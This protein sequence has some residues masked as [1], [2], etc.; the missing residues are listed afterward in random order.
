MLTIV[1]LATVLKSFAVKYFHFG[2][3][4]ACVGQRSLTSPDGF[5][6][7]SCKKPRHRWRHLMDSRQ[8]I[9]ELE[10]YDWENGTGIGAVTGHNNLIVLDFDDCND[11]T[12]ILL[13]LTLLGLTTKYEWAV[14]SG[15]GNG[16][17]IWFFVTGELPECC[18]GKQVITFKSI[19]RDRLKQIEIRLKQHTVLP[20]SIH[21]SGNQYSFLNCEFPE[22]KPSEVTWR[23]V[24]NMLELFVDMPTTPQGN[25]HLQ[26]F[27]FLDKRIRK[28]I[29][30]KVQ[31]LD[32][33]SQEFPDADILELSND[34]FKFLGKGGFFVNTK[35]NSWWCFEDE[36]GGGPLEAIG[37]RLFGTA[38]DAANKDHWKEVFDTAEEL[39][40]TDF[41]DEAYAEYLEDL[42]KESD[43]VISYEITEFLKQDEKGDAKLFAQINNKGLRFNFDEG[44]WYTYTSGQ[45]RK[46]KKQSVRTKLAPELTRVYQQQIESLTSQAKVNSDPQ[47]LMKSEIQELRNRIK[48]L[49]K[50]GRS[51]GV[52]SFAASLLGA[53]SKDFDTNPLLF[54][55]ANGT[56]D[57]AKG[58]L[59][60]HSP[61]DLCTIQADYCYDP[62]VTCPTFDKFLS[63]MFRND[64]E[65]LRYMQKSIGLFLSG[66]TDPGK[67]WYFWGP[68][69][70][71]KTTLI[72]ILKML[73]G[74]YFVPVNVECLLDGS[75]N[76]NA[77]FSLAAVSKARVVIASELP[78]G[79]LLNEARLKGLTGGDPIV[80]RD[81]YKQMVSFV[82]RFKLVMSGNHPLEIQSTGTA[83]A[84][85]L[86]IIPCTV[87]IPVEEQMP[88]S[89]LLAL[90]RPELPGILN[91]AVEGYRMYLEE[92]LK[93][94]KLVENA[95]SD[96][97]NSVREQLT[98][99]ID[100]CCEKDTDA[101]CTLQAFYKSFQ[102]YW[103]FY[104]QKPADDNK[105]VAARL[106]EM[107][108]RVANNKSKKNTVTVYGLKIRPITQ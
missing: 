107:G 61:E 73:L 87:V 37:Y 47:G 2:F 84:R 11:F 63:T 67:L 80:G 106:R 16:Y 53:E 85:R 108:I 51:E 100:D 59:R 50:I 13:A 70:T 22:A 79:K 28:E 57:L 62:S 42:N 35:K 102:D 58:E 72:M 14:R 94:P 82:P 75:V 38:F 3:N 88:R 15:S 104:K 7:N 89:E 9:Q 99:F 12:V 17:H 33:F 56:V 97:L 77:L 93:A 83:I 65:L 26:E 98:T 49:N 76:N 54:N 4:V 92:G 45:W 71:A 41:G 23:D 46:D 36:R 74:E 105:R 90:I 10:G 6:K 21:Q 78:E 18:K 29:S 30:S 43:H 103:E 52:I 39:L 95:T 48:A 40:D 60:N 55:V 91:F 31:V 86:Q 68:A 5:E 24:F 20:F 8:D 64:D 66:N 96:L 81:P 25:K 101:S 32:Y 34:E 19:D 1:L 27:P 44:C 69:S